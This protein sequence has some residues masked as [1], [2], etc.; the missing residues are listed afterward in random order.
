MAYKITNE[1][2]SSITINY[3]TDDYYILDYDTVS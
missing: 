2:Y 1:N 3:N